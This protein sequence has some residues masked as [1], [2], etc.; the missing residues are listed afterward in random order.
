M[1]FIAESTLEKLLAII[2]PK[3]IQCV[4]KKLLKMSKTI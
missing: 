4:D 2:S 3:N 1:I